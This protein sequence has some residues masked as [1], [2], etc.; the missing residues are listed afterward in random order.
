MG[1]IDLQTDLKSLKYGSEKPYI[2]KDVNNPQVNSGIL[3]QVDKRVD[4]LTR[5]SKL[6][7]DKPGVKFVANQS[8][9][10]QEGFSDKINKR[11]TEDGNSTGGA[12]LRQVGQTAKKVTGI[13]GSTLAQVP[14]N[15]TGTH[16]V[17]G[18]VPNTYLKESREGSQ[19]AQ[20]FGAGNV[21]GAPLALRGEKVPTSNIN[22]NFPTGNIQGIGDYTDKFTSGSNYINSILDL[23]LDTQG[24]TL[25]GSSGIE[26][27]PTNDGTQ[28]NRQQQ[29]AIKERVS[30]LGYDDPNKEIPQDSQSNSITNNS[31]LA[32][33]GTPISLTNRRG[34]FL[35][36]EIKDTTAETGSLN[37]KPNTDNGFYI[38]RISRSTIGNGA[39]GVQDFRSDNAISGSTTTTYSFNYNS[40]NINREQR[41]GLGNQGKK[42]EID[43]E[44]KYT[45]T[46]PETVDK[47]NALGVLDSKPS[48]EESRDFISLNFQVITPETTKYLYFR[49]YLDTFS[50]SFNADWGSTKYLGRAENMYTYNGFDRNVSLGFKIAAS[51][52]EEM[53]PIYQKMNYLASTTA[54]TYGDDSFMKGTLVKVT[55][56][57]YLYEVPAVVNSVQYS[58]Q[59]EYPWEI[60][61]SNP[62]SDIDDDM[63]VLPHILDCS[64]E[65]SIIH[66]FIPQTGD[67]P[68]VSNPFGNQF[69][70]QAWTTLPS[71]SE[72]TA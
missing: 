72:Q 65:L 47:L 36:G 4:D 17:H 54:P 1:L 58:W 21:E 6:L 11:R 20:F 32:K 38:P 70:K 67:V 50:D 71:E 56:G 18:L 48:L 7:T 45:K 27:I 60:S 14:V 25:R 69:N 12:I 62:E 39:I 61:M 24:T 26:I 41:V 57:D 23:N 8:F 10:Q 22:S 52:R 63:Q 42:I 9:L 19:F 37:S 51:T 59:T 44:L 34:T 28:T 46:D 31:N 16:F 43:P 29:S 53:R 2:T 49:A 33:N 3:N 66:N 68:F 15:G 30:R 13:I 64:V 40:R 5:I 55:V 35:N